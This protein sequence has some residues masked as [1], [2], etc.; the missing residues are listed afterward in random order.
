MLYDQ[1]LSFNTLPIKWVY[2]RSILV[3]TIEAILFIIMIKL[4]GVQIEGTGLLE[5]FAGV[6]IAFCLLDNV[7]SILSSVGE[8]L[9]LHGCR[10]VG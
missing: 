1:G 4:L 6:G 9:A 3:I 10:H 5:W 8:V 2:M 7:R